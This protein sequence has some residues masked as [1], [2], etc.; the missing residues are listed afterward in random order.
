MIAI[1]WVTKWVGEVNL[2][3][4]N[5]VS[6]S[7]GV[8]VLEIAV[9][10]DFAPTQVRLS[11]NFH[12]RPGCRQKSLP[13]KSR[14]G[15]GGQNPILRWP[16]GKKNSSEIEMFKR[17]PTKPLC[18]LLVGNSQSLKVKIENLASEIENFKREAVKGSFGETVVFEQKL[19]GG[20][21]RGFS[22]RGASSCTGVLGAG[23]WGQV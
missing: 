3:S 12:R 15:A 11:E 1:A 13:R 18:F 9:G 23:I 10:A 16:S 4:G 6:L 8:K 19:R 20:F 21:L 22:Q 17:P 7:K 2:Y 5:L 14:V